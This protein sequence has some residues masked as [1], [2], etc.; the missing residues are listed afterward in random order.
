[1][2]RL[3]I[4]IPSIPS[5]WDKAKALYDHIAT[6]IGDRDIEVLLL[7]DNKRRT[8]GEKREALKNAANGKYF[9]FCDDD[10]SLYSIDE[11]Y[12]AT[13]NDVDV[14]TFKSKCRNSD[15]ST[16]IVTA[17][18]RNE[19]EH[20]TEDGRYLDCKR[21]PFTQS[22]WASRFKQ[23]SF[24]ATNYSEDWEWVKQCLP[25]AFLE[26]H[27]DKVLHGYNFDPEVSEATMEEAEQKLTEEIN[28]YE[29]TVSWTRPDS[30][31]MIPS[32]VMSEILSFLP[33]KEPLMNQPY[34]GPEPRCC[35]V[36]VATGSH[37]KGQQRL[38]HSLSL[39]T[40]KDRLMYQ[41]EAAVGA[42]LHY[43]NPYSFKIHA[44]EKAREWYDQIL[45]LD[46]S[47]Y[48]VK[49]PQP[50][51][52]WLTKHGVFME[53]AG[54]YVGQWCN[55]ETLNYF[56]ITREDAMTMPMFSAGF[57]GFDFR[58]EIAREFF[59]RW[60]NAMMAGMFKGSWSNHRHDMTVGSIIANQMGLVSIYSKGGTFFSYIGPGFGEPSP[61][62]VFH[63]AGMP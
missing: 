37:I 24:P 50:V 21:P 4:L 30:N 11:I 17:G 36:N 58:Q 33:D 54:H 51:F 26:T 6:L 7:M 22:A 5:R 48:A 19:V 49:D 45:W 39:T 55:D 27:I 44:I 47:V 8:I 63:L 3:S 59:A 1:M 32:G 23:F 9:M 12:E 16:Y 13:A 14:I 20:N 28:Q 15:G 43:S 53:E 35:I 38:S 46:A 10:D 31:K 40:S 18:L 52:D 56:G 57:V 41:S 62:S 29:K 25:T 42:E 34:I 61:T 60:K 2:T